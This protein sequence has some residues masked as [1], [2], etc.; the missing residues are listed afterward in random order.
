MASAHMSRHPTRLRH[1]GDSGSGT[2]EATA[3]I[4][5]LRAVDNQGA[6]SFAGTPYWAGNRYRGLIAGVRVV[7][8][9]VQVT[10]DGDLVRTHKVRHDRS[11]EFGALAMPKGKPRRK[12]VA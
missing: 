1:M 12:S 3:G 10:I 2:Y 6:V 5:V 11:K 7:G 9:T 8:D 4:E